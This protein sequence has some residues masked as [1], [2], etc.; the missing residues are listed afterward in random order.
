VQIIV[1]SHLVDS[2][3]PLILVLIHVNLLVYY[4]IYTE[5]GAI[6]SKIPVTPG[7]PYLGRIMAKFVPPPRNAKAVKRSIAKVENIKDRESS[8]IF[9]TPY[10]KS[11]MNDADRFT[12]INNTGPGYS[13]YAP[14][15]LVAKMS[16]SER[17]ASSLESDGTRRCGLTNAA[18]EPDTTVTHP[19]IQY[20]TSTQRFHN[21]FLF[22]TSCIGGS[23][24]CALCR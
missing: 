16:D 9:L 22:V 2:D 6:P 13:A 5:D 20:R 14:V 1:S 3:S 10:S 12:I 21:N 19:E 7:D 4:R 18:A 17:S 15:A 8:S 24:L 11:P 23:I